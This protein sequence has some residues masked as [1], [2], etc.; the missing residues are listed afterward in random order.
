[1]GILAWKARLYRYFDNLG[2]LSAILELL[3]FASGI[4]AILSQYT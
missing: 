3:V 1:V 2:F 4:V